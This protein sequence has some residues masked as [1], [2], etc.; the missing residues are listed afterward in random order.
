[1]ALLDFDNTLA[2]GWIL[3]PWLQELGSA[4]IGRAAEGYEEL[5]GLF[6]EYRVRP[7]FG[8]DRLATEAARIYATSLTGVSVH[9]VK[10]LAEPFA[11]DYL[12]RDGPLF[13]SSRAL[14]SGLRERGHR[15]ILVTGAPSELAEPLMRELGFERSFALVLEIEGGIYTGAIVAN[16]GL[17]SAKAKVCEHLA[18]SEESEVVVAVGDSEGDRPLWRHAR[19]AIRVGATGDD[20]ELN[21]SALNLEEP[22]DAGFWEMIP[23]ASWLSELARGRISEEA[24]TRR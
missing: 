12:G 13:P 22:L 10:P 1:V 6:A 3:G 20:A 23:T 24:A 7:G 16:S 2:R 14:L 5:A 11:V 21:V 18:E 17:S 4:G 8:H 19:V 9:D 15:T